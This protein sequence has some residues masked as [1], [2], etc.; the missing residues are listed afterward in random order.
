MREGLIRTKSDPKTKK[1]VWF[2]PYFRA[3]DKLI[4]KQEVVASESNHSK[5]RKL[6]WLDSLTIAFLPSA[7]APLFMVSPQ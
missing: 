1:I 4:A 7:F 3:A 2:L 6:S 5:Y